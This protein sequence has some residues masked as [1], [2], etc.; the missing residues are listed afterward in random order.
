MVGNAA[1]NKTKTVELLL[2]SFSLS[3]QA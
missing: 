3:K 1:A 2:S